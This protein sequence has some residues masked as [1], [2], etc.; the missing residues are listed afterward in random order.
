MNPDGAFVYY[1]MIKDLSAYAS[2]KARSLAEHPLSLEAKLGRG[3]R[4]TRLAVPDAAIVAGS[5]L[6]PDDSQS[7]E[8]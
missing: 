6:L 3:H 4:V 7:S 8:V 2:F 1:S 5:V